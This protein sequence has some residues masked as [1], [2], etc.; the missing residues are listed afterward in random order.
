[1]TLK[2]KRGTDSQRLATTPQ[3]AE[4][5]W[6]TDT[7]LLYVGDGSTAGGIAV[8]AESSNDIFYADNPQIITSTTATTIP[9]S[10]TITDT[11]FSVASDE[12][13][14]VN[15]GRY[16]I[17]WN[18]AIAILDNGNRNGATATLDRSTDSGTT[19]TTQLQTINFTT[20][21]T[22]ASGDFFTGS[23]SVVI[24]LTAGD[25]IRWQSFKAES[26]GTIVLANS[27]YLIESI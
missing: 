6:A 16:R 1:M 24:T 9:L 25:V 10:N 23:R 13:T 2:V 4:P 8:G 27:T 12:V 20:T 11:G 26:T 15:A 19:F 22:S 7:K 21:G 5:V 17:S 14:V 3:L 18:G